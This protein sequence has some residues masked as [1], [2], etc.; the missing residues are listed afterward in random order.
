MTNINNLH[1]YKKALIFVKELGKLE[2]S[3]KKAL[4]DI[5]K[6]KKYLPAQECIEVLSNNLTIVQVHLTHQKKIIEDKGKE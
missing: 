2:I 5:E 4:E 6:Y 3:M 1:K